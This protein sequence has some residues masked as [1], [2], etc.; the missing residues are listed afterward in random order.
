MSVIG[1][2]V[3]GSHGLINL[4]LKL[5][6]LSTRIIDEILDSHKILDISW[7]SSDL[8][9][10]GFKFGCHLEVCRAC[11]FSDQF[12]FLLNNGLVFL[13]VGI[14]DILGNDFED[15]YGNRVRDL[16]SKF[17]LELSKSL[18]ISHQTHGIHWI[19]FIW[20][21][22]FLQVVIRVKLMLIILELLEGFDI[23]V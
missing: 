8:C 10:E 2:N 14:P 7:D 19:T 4:L 23:I 6:E 9:I 11:S 18:N 1:G 5:L 20:L 12:L 21:L 3:I 22:N 15:R 13:V 16:F 17:F